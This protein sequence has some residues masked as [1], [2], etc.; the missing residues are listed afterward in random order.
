MARKTKTVAMPIFNTA[1]LPIVQKWILRSLLSLGGYKHWIGKNGLTNDEIAHAIELECLIEHP[2]QSALSEIIVVALK[3]RLGK[4]EGDVTDFSVQPE[5]IQNI[6]R[7]QT[8]VKLNP[9]E[10]SILEF[11]ILLHSESALEQAMDLFANLSVAMICHALSV[12]LD[13]PKK[14]IQK[15]L[16]TSG[17]LFQTGLVRIDRNRICSIG[18]RNKLDLL[19][20]GFADRMLSSEEDPVLLFMDS[21]SQAKPPQLAITDYA[22]IEPKLRT[23]LPYLR[24]TL[25]AGSRGVNVF[26][27]GP[28]GTG[29]SQL[30]RVLAAEVEAKLYEVS[31][32]DSDRDPI[33]GEARL[34]ALRAAQTVLADKRCLLVFDETEDVF[35]DG[36]GM[37]GKKSTAQTRKAWIN[38]MLE[39]NPVPCLWLSN[40]VSQ[41]DPAF[42]RRFDVVIELTVPGKTQRAN[43]IKSV[44]SDLLSNQTVQQLAEA[45]ELSP[46]VVSRAVRVIKAIRGEFSEEETSDA[47]AQLVDSTLVAQSHAPLKLRNANQLPDFYDPAFVNADVCLEQIASGIAQSGSARLCLYGPPGTGKSAFGCWLADKLGKP[48][49]VRKVSDIASSYVGETEKNLARAFREAEIEKGVLLLDEVDS[50]LQDRRRANRN[51]EVTEVNEMLTQMECFGGVFVAST[52]LMEGLDQAAL[53][54]FDLKVKFGYLQPDQAWQLFLR[55]AE[56]LGLPI[57]ESA[58]ETVC[59]KL[60]VLTPGDFAAVARQARF[61]P[62]KSASDMLALLE[63]ECALKED[64]R[65]Q[66]IG[67]I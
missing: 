36:S 41:I 40:S 16:S 28:P 42:I 44:G 23:L 5:L 58:K 24:H 32:E 8:L 64:G 62:I 11:T 39:E 65:R 10:R 61:R 52:N 31:S 35:A 46:A 26:V 9:V 45:E 27:Y 25:N 6:D 3:T 19:G 43:I 56:A 67:F 55:H 34:R 37:F 48:L 29:K 7:L 2:V 20:N 51:W 57:N 21:F 60:T 49:L 54:R 59:R 14:D 50:F 15:A 30:A 53:R 1:A 13:F 18:L 47:V 63:A 4:L 38:R 66:V 33:N 22:Y 12:L 17:Q